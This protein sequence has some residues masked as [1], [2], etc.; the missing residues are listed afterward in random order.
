[1]CLEFG[2]FKFI[3]FKK[4]VYEI[5]VDLIMSGILGLNVV[6]RFIVGFVLEFIVCYVLCDVLV[7]CIEELLV[8]F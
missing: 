1:M 5:N 4:F 7:V 8:D 6:E 2:F 3:I